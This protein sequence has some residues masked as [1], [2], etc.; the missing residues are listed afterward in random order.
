MTHTLDLIHGSTTVNLNSS[1]LSI[2][3]YAPTDSGNGMVSEQVVIRVEGADSSALQS[4][5][6]SIKN[7]FRLANRRFDR[8]HGDRVYVKFQPDGYSSAYRSEL[9]RPRPDQDAGTISHDADVL[10]PKWDNKK[11]RITISWT[12]RNYWEANSESELSLANGGGSGTGGQTIYNIHGSAAL[13][14]TSISFTAATDRISDSNNGLGVFAEGDIIS[15]RG[16]TDNDGVYS[17]ETVAGDG[18]TLDINE[19]VLTDEAAGD[20]VSIYDIQNYVEIDSADISGDLDAAIRVEV[21]NSDGGANLET[22]WAGLNNTSNPANF[23]HLLEIGD[24]DTGSNSSDA[25]S[26]NGIKRTY[27]ITTS[28]AKVTGWTLPSSMLT[29]SDGGYFKVFLRSPNGTNLTDIKLRLKVIYSSTTIWEGELVEYDDTYANIARLIRAVDT[30]QL[31]PYSPE[32]N[33]PDDIELQLFGVST[34]GGNESVDI[35]CLILMPLDGYRRLRSLGGV[36]QNDLIVD[37]GIFDLSFAETSTGVIV[38]D[39]STVGSHLMIDPNEDNRLYFLQ[40]SVTANT[41]DY[42]RSASVQVYYRERKASL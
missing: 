7:A 14:D 11:I 9:I 35:D 8:G 16:S 36:A 1:N 4:S 15:V 13:S 22:V 17:V 6:E 27:T 29:A 40:H 28:E 23:P 3:S 41:A 42:D 2:M 31:P 10:G 34:S 37:D 39:V 5:L 20:S 24:S 19:D 18:S 26:A 21:T 38:R 25:S 30:V 32:G 12:R 33:T